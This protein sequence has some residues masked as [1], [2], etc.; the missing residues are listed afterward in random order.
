MSTTPV[1][2]ASYRRHGQRYL[3]DALI[4]A[5]S[6][7]LDD[8][9]EALEEQSDTGERLGQI[10]L[11]REKIGAYGLAQGLASIFDMTVVDLGTVVPDPA[12]VIRVPEAVARRLHALPLWVDDGELVIAIDDPAN[13]TALDD[14]QSVAG[15]TARFVVAQTDQLEQAID[16]AWQVH[17]PDADRAATVSESTSPAIIG[18]ERPVVRFIDQL[19]ARAL[20]EQASDVHLE[21]TLSGG[22]VRFRVDGMLHDV[23]TVEPDL[24]A[25]ATARLK[26]MADLNIAVRRLPQDG[27]MSLSIS[28]TPLDVR[29]GTLPTSLGEA[30]VLRLLDASRGLLDIAD[31]GFNPDTL[32]RFEDAYHKPWGEVLVT[33]PTGSGKTTTLYAAVAKINRSDQNIV[34]VENPVEYQIDGI[35]QVQV[36]EAAGLTFDRA[37]RAILRCDPDVILVGEIRDAETARIAAEAAL[38]GHLVLS[39]MHTNDAASAP[40]RLVEMGLQPYLVA[41]ALDCVVAQRLARGLCLHCREQYAATEFELAAAGWELTGLPVPESLYR[42]RGCPDCNGTGYRGRFAVHEL[43]RVT[44]EIREVILANRSVEALRAVGA[45]D[46]MLSMR[47]DGLMKAAAGRTSFE[48]IIR[49][50][51]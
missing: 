24:L 7:G 26:V 17:S 28:G 31:L 27:R 37:L 51:T 46:G 19:M 32:A 9:A 8:L 48:E 41:A 45:E 44:P 29:V 14:L 12:V 25:S 20:N 10:L 22:R 49:V 30:V 13:L 23:L 47:A 4:D 6:V 39:T 1:R 5:G 33:G 11:S 42:H 36:A 3:G 38:T 15:M 2:P 16:A 43:L 34:T 35:K 18:D 21:A 40:L 50:T